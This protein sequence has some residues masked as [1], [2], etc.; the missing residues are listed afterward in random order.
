MSIQR[1]LAR[2]LRVGLGFEAGARLRGC[3]T[4]ALGGG[5]AGDGSGAA[6]GGGGGGG[7]GGD[8]VVVVVV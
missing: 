4:F 5:A 3:V 7:G 8:G 1:P 6:R 2:E